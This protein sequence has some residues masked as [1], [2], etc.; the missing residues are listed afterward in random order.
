[1]V[2]KLIPF[3]V[4]PL[5]PNIGLTLLMNNICYSLIGGDIG[6]TGENSRTVEK[7][8]GTSFIQGSAPLPAGAEFCCAANLGN[9]QFILVSY[10]GTGM[11]TIA[12]LHYCM[13]L[14]I[15]VFI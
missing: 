15:G 2:I 5:A 12:L 13:K 6:A 9:D 14:F 8:S 3:I 10:A 11:V 4:Y 7:L 1:M